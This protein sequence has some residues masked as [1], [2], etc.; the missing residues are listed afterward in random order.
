VVTDLQSIKISDGEYWEYKPV[1]AVMVIYKDGTTKNIFDFNRRKE[2]Q[3]YENY[4]RSLLWRNDDAFYETEIKTPD[5]ENADRIRVSVERR[6]K[7][8]ELVNFF[9]VRSDYNTLLKRITFTC[10]EASSIAMG[11][12]NKENLSLKTEEKIEKGKKIFTIVGN[13]IIRLPEEFHS[14]YPEAWYA[15]LHL[16]L[17]PTG[18]TSYT[19][20]QLG[21]FDLKKMNDS[22]EG[23]D[24]D[25]LDSIART[26]WAA[27]EDR[28]INNAFCL[29]KD[30]VRYY[31]S[32]EKEY[33][34]IPRDPKTVFKQGYG[35]CKEMATILTLLLRKSGLAAWQTN[36]M[37]TGNMQY[38]EQYPTLSFNHMIVRVEKSN[39]QSVYLD[40]THKGATTLT[41][42]H[43]VLGQK[44]L[45]LKN[46]GASEIDTIKPDPTYTNKIITHSQVLPPD[47]GNNWKIQGT[48]QCL[49]EIAAIEYQNLTNLE[50]TEQPRA[51]RNI[52]NNL[53]QIQ[54]DQ[55][56]L[57]TCKQECVIIAF[58][59]DFTGNALQTPAKGLIFSLPALYVPQ[60][61]FSDLSYE[62][63]RYL[64][65]F[66]QT[67]TWSFP[68]EY[69]IFDCS[70]LNS[71]F[72]VGTWKT[73]KNTLHRSYS[74]IFSNIDASERENLKLF[75]NE[76]NTF[77]RGIAWSK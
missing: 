57:T 11:L 1:I 40:A 24:T 5:Y 77:A 53:L 33:G 28:R 67:D 26:I 43:H 48:M 65:R 75:L 51:L 16:S 49:G 4:Y 69:G 19:W 34:W 41:S 20:Q 46:G 18:N 55:A 59:A 66:E 64:C 68:E 17:P 71:D 14:K 37:T 56:T 7:R 30:K 50:N 42:Y 2:T 9:L 76:R 54:A 3:K 27:N 72:G 6:I 32:W 12:T 31:G 25:F 35:D 70:T 8:C 23:K 10:P 38:L 45:V 63:G 62:G 29:V 60:R 13:N 74:C 73:E 36:V 15:A 21:D 44:V 61:S 47:Q 22:L 58:T 52:L 39:G